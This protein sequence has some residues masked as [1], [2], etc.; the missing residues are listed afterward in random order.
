MVSVKVIYSSTGKPATSQK[1]SV[2][3]DGWTRGFSKTEYTD[4]NGEVHFD[5]DPGNGTIYVN[6]NSKYVG[7]I[8]G[9]KVIYI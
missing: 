8:E 4:K 9:M 1:V 3:F 2:G 7:R 6:G 5:N